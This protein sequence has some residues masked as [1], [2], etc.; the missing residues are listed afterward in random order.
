MGCRGEIHDFLDAALGKHGHACLTAG[1][2]VGMIP[3]D[4]QRMCGD[5]SCRHMDDAGKQFPCHAVQVGQHQKQTLG[6]GE[7]G[8]QTA[9]QQRAVDCRCR[10]GF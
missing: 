4:G 1:I 6:G 3:E 10:A 9:C 5:G 8:G 7:S 2:N